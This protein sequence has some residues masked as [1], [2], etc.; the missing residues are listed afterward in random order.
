MVLACSG[1]DDD[2]RRA[3]CFRAA[4]D[5]FVVDAAE[6][7]QAE[8]A[9]QAVQAE[10]AAKEGLQSI[11]AGAESIPSERLGQSRATADP[12][13]SPPE[14]VVASNEPDAR[15]EVP[16]V[17]SRP[18]APADQP[19]VENAVTERRVAQSV[20]SVPNR[21]SAT[22]TAVHA[23]VRDRQ[24]VALDN[25][26]VFE[27]GRASIARIKVG[28]PVDVVRTSAFFGRRFRMI[29]PSHRPFTGSRI[30]CERLDLSDSNRRKC[31]AVIGVKSR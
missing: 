17:S 10:K 14:P 13:T 11:K 3:E 12:P 25:K 18:P 22:V 16:S 2:A 20:I 23:L 28:D 19:A 15:V 6:A 1:I 7:V 5:R 9:V 8:K 30:R 26:L 24:L 27:G 21:F 4:S 31:D 29:G